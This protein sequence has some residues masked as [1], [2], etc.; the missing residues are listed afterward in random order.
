M[1][2]WLQSSSDMAERIRQH[3]WAS[4][5]LGP[6]ELW[7]DVLKTTVALCLASS[8]PQAIIW[9]PRL[10]TL[11]NDAFVPILGNKPYALGR[12]F[13]QIWS[14]AWD[15]IGP[16]ADAA[17]EGHATYIEN[18]PLVI[19]RSATPEQAYFTFCYSP[20]R[21]P[22]GRVVG[23]LDTVTETTAT[24]FLSRRLTVLDAIGNAVA[25]A[26][27]AE[28]IMTATTRLLAQHLQVSICAYADMDADEDGFTIRDNWT[29]PGSPSI[30]GHYSLKAFGHTAVKHLR[31]G[32]PL[33]IRNHLVEL[34]AHESLSFQALGVAATICMPLIKNGRLTALMAVHNKTERDWSAY[35][36]ALLG[37]VTE[38]SWAHI[39][40]VR[41]NAAVREGLAAFTELN[42]TLEQRVEE[43]TRLLTQTEAALR[44]SQ[45]LEAIGQLTGGV[46]HDFNNLLTI[47]RS[48]VDFLRQP[49][50]S[51]ERRQRYMSAVSDTVERASKLT[52][53]LLAFAR[54]QPLNPEVFDVGQ[55][56]QNIA[57]MLESVTG[58]RIQVRVNLPEQPC[59]VRVDSSQFEAAL[60]NIAL[61]ARDAMDSQ[62]TLTLSVARLPALPRIRGDAE[63]RQPFVAVSLADTGSGI[64]GDTLERIFEPFFTTKAVGKGTGLGLSQVFGFAKQSGGNVDVASTLGEGTVFTLYLPEAEP[65]LT[66]NEPAPAE[67]TPFDTSTLR[68]ILIVEDNLEVG[69]FAN[70]ILQDLGYQTTWVTDAEQALALAGP[71]ARAFDAIFSD[72]VMPGMTGVAM[73]KVLRQRRA[74]LPV[75]L[76][77]GYSDELADN[78]Y[79]G[80]AFLAKPYS[81]DQ[82]AQVLAKAMLKD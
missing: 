59:H 20:I 17:F 33:V 16:I 28:T 48:S 66:G 15:E 81:A 10:I 35:D 53:Q 47:I 67:P 57:E 74:D 1:M 2:N 58:A 38:R 34:P 72:V 42:A 52:S 21:D 68:N 5:T 51:E 64:A 49:G 18:F 25:N 32:E 31:A 65:Q 63:S 79:E 82:V 56:V 62:G 80:F 22:K 23:M 77:S 54:R 60:I 44:Q 43:R 55:R 14:E 46:A 26:T 45:K 24:V 71:D 3:D 73:A 70:Q 50:L 40:R 12:P 29:A 19:E 37:E 69:R 61:N 78:G 76:T 4:T 9:G 11:Y 39:E 41:A 6:I 30:T 8:F 27:D 36:L 13:S 7:P 75:V